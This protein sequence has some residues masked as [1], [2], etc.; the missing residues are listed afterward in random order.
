MKS[1][2][3]ALCLALSSG[4]IFAPSPWALA[5]TWDGSAAGN[6]QDATN[7]SLDVVPTGTATVFINTTTPTVVTYDSAANFMTSGQFQ[8][9]V[10][11]GTNS[12]LNIAAGAGSLQFGGDAFGSAARIGA[13]GGSG[14][15]NVSGGLLQF[16]TGLSGND[17]SLNLAGHN[18]GG[19]NTGILNISGGEVQ[20]GRRILM[21]A[22]STSQTAALT[23]SGTGVLNMLATGSNAEGDLG[24]LR[25][26]NG[27][28]TVNFDGGE[29]RGRGIRQDATTASTAVYYNGTQFRLNGNSGTGAAGFIGSG[30]SGINQ[31]KEGGLKINT[32]GFDGVIARGISNYTG[33]AGTLTKDGAGKLTFSSGG[34]SYS[35]TV[36]NAGQVDFTAS[37]V[38][39]NHV[40]SAHQLTINAG[41]LVTNSTGAGGYVTLS[42]LNLNGG[43]LRATNTLSALSGVFQAYGIKDTVTVGGTTASMISDVGQANGGISIGGTADLGGGIGFNA[44]FNIADV[45][46][47]TSA[48]LLVSAKFKNSANGSFVAL[49]T[50]IDKMGQGTMSLSGVNSYTGSTRILEG[51]LAITGEG[52]IA[53]STTIEISSGAVL[54]VSATTDPWQLA[55]GQKLIG[56]GTIR[57]ATVVNGQLIAGNSIGSITFANGLSLAGITL[58]EVDAGL[59]LS[60]LV[61]VGSSLAFGGVLDVANLNGTFAVG[62]SFNL[63]DFANGTGTFSQV[64]LPTL[65]E[66]LAWDQSLLYENG[67]ISVVTVVPEPGVTTLVGLCA[68]LSLLHRRRTY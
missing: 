10:G 29:F 19:T 52:S 65:N 17:T 2:N 45:T 63:F 8:L 47:N 44:I 66:G 58:L 28:N 59:N 31:I 55:N 57:G 42:N 51:T 32:N 41:A 23:L 50:G 39:G 27:T 16:G 21:G 40:A 62:Q 53:T 61:T 22:N 38:F 24:M 35:Q 11:A 6:W 20:I 12:T 34:S 5:D 3:H 46:N 60:D 4:V 26:G 15:I 43:E 36:V 37:D 56:D 9:G 49:A 14:T 18:S 30:G 7:W 67:S 13:S 25:L 48:D 68:S 64:N 1:V 54:D 33:V